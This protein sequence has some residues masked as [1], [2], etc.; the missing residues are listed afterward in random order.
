MV[1][2]IT[3]YLSSLAISFATETNIFA[4]V[5]MITQQS[6]GVEIGQETLL[7]INLM[8]VR[9]KVVILPPC[10]LLVDVFCILEL[11]GPNS[12]KENL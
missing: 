8:W 11:Y 3:V 4:V 2:S 10:P 5:A 12:V 1:L 7:V 9:T 6:F